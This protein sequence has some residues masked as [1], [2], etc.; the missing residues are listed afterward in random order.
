MVPLT[1]RSTSELGGRISDAMGTMRGREQ[2]L[3]QT[4]RMTC[5]TRSVTQPMSSDG[6]RF[7]EP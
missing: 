5:R 1:P 4:L 2:F 3:R 7:R 6:Q